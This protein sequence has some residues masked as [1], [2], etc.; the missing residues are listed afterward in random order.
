MLLKGPSAMAGGG[1][2]VVAVTEST[3]GRGTSYIAG[4][5]LQDLEG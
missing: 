3:R 4:I 5:L 1:V 2:V